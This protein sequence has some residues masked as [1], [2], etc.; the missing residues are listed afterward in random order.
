MKLPTMG[1]VVAPKLLNPVKVTA[2]PLATSGLVETK[3]SEYL[4]PIAL[5]SGV[6]PAALVQ[7]SPSYGLEPPATPIQMSC[8]PSARTAANGDR[9]ALGYTCV[10]S[11]PR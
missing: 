6:R 7:G 10:A 9:S 4:N 5:Y 3:S 8:A 2:S 1:T 11:A